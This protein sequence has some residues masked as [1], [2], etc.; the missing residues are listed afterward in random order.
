MNG[1]CDVSGTF[2]KWELTCGVLN[3]WRVYQWHLMNGICDLSG[4]I[5]KWETTWEDGRERVH[6][7]PK[8]TDTN[9]DTLYTLLKFDLAIRKKP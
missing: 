7:I 5:V 1:S 6:Q 8:W 4:V 9:I 3:S 2:A